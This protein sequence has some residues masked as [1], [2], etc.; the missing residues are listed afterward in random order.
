MMSLIPAVEDILEKK[1]LPRNSKLEEI[2]SRYNELIQ[3]GVIKKAQ[4]KTFGDVVYPVDYSNKHINYSL[5]D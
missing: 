1:A 3:R 2:Q 5:G 4:P